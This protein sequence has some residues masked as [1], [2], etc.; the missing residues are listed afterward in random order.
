MGQGI[1]VQISPI[2]LKNITFF[3][4]SCQTSWTS[5]RKAQRSSLRSPGLKKWNHRGGA[6]CLGKGITASISNISFMGSMVQNDG[7]KPK[8][9]KVITFTIV[10]SCHLT[11][12]GPIILNHSHTSIISFAIIFTISLQ[13]FTM[14]C[15]LGSTVHGPSRGKL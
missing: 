12:G 13:V 9:T 6:R 8:I 7:T 5:S 11:F 4:M 2:F 14:R 15:D 10:K 3:F 1:R